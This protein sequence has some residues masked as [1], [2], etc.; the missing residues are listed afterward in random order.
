MF[1]ASSLITGGSKGTGG[2]DV[3]TMSNTISFLDLSTVDN[4]YFCQ[5]FTLYKNYSNPYN[6]WKIIKYSV[7]V[8]QNIEPNV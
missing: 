4:D 1:I 7:S 5:D 6:P 8:D 2:N 3:Y